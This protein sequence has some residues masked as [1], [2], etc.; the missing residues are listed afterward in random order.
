V[1]TTEG[2]TC[3]RSDAGQVALE[4]VTTAAMEQELVRQPVLP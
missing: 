1:P 4:A 2:T 3:D